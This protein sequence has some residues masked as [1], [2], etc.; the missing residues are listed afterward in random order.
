MSDLTPPRPGNDAPAASAATPSTASRALIAAAAGTTVDPLQREGYA[1]AT[2]RGY[3][4]A[5]G[6]GL[7]LALTLVILGGIY[8][9]HRG[10]G[11]VR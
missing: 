11:S 7:A 1:K 2:N 9:A 8:L 5:M 4:D 3:G 10:S 6:R